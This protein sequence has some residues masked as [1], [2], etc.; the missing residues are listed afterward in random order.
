MRTKDLRRDS[1]CLRGRG[2]DP[3]RGAGPDRDYE[4]LFRFLVKL[5]ECTGEMRGKIFREGVFK[6]R[7]GALQ[8]EGGGARGENFM[9]LGLFRRSPNRYGSLEIP[10]LEGMC[11]DWACNGACVFGEVGIAA[12]PPVHD[13]RPE[14]KH[15]GI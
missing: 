6:V 9:A 10:R 4:A 1:H 14:K 15:S 12:N 7:E 11:G 13:N 2:N 5:G 3:G 8:G